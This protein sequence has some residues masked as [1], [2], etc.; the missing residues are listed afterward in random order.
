ME[1]FVA[2]ENVKRFKKQLSDCT[3]E[4]QRKTLKQLLA[5]AETHLAELE[6]RPLALGT[7]KDGT[8]T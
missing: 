1:L 2:S 4:Q 5:E 3:D 7:T 8:L 6:H